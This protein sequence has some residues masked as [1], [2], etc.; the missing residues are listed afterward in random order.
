MKNM[1]VVGSRD[2][3]LVCVFMSNNASDDYMRKL[4]FVLVQDFKSVVLHQIF[5]FWQENSF[6][7]GDV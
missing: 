3:V 5:N 2:R 7:V 4:R 1:E 6:N